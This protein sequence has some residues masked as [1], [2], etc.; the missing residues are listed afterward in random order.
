M[1]IP[2]IETAPHAVLV[3]AGHMQIRFLEYANDRFVDVTDYV[4]GK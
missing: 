3:K 4:S 1:R 2:A